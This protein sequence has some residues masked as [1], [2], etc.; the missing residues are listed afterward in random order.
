[1]K[2]AILLGM[3]FVSYG[4]AADWYKI[5]NAISTRRIDEITELIAKGI[6][7]E[8]QLNAI[9]L[10]YS[11]Y[12][13]ALNESRFHDQAKNAEWLRFQEYVRWW[14]NTYPNMSVVD[15][16]QDSRWLQRVRELDRAALAIRFDA[17]TCDQIVKRLR[18][19]T[20]TTNKV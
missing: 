1:M 12:D 19:A 4:Y 6:S 3:F 9:Q 11:A 20:I 17:L 10:A 13:K 2:Y 7:R 8:V 14:N 18:D 16:S 15:A 5:R